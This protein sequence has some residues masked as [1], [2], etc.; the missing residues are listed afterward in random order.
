LPSAC[1]AV[2]GGTAVTCLDVEASALI[3]DRSRGRVYAL[4]MG[5][6]AKY[7]NEL[8]V[9]DPE[10][11]TVETSVF[12][13]SEPDSLVLSDDATRL[14]VGLHGAYAIREVDLT[15]WPPEPGA[16]YVV[17]RGPSVSRAAYAG[18]MIALAGEPESIAV[19]LHND[20]VSP[21]GAGVAVLDS[22]APRENRVDHRPA[23]TELSSG[24]PGYLF[25]VDDQQQ[26]V[27]MV[28]DESGL[29]DTRVGGLFRG[30]AGS[31]VYDQGF[32]F[33]STGHVLDVSSPDAP[34]LVGSFSGPGLIV[35]HAAE[36]R[37]VMLSSVDD[38][39]VE[40]PLAARY[41]LFLRR[42]DISTLQHDLE[43]V[44]DGRFFDARDLVEPMPGY[45]AFGNYQLPP[46]AGDD[47]VFVRSA[48]VIL[49]APEFA[50]AA[51]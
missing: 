13:G 5:G 39:S 8:V 48:V 24:P 42:L 3:A 33:T 43:W 22:G 1:E 37:V 9:I 14:W 29:A 20:G 50:E 23:I 34:A 45:F 19:A 30:G 51:P 2:P 25:G 32:L 41:E 26:L 11:A 15:R 12:V 46:Y 47:Q 27:S 31:L 17:P 18:A 4:V 6:A 36:S 28:V 35:S 38:L 44:L 49:A 21:S 16:Q 7:A 10:S 40:D